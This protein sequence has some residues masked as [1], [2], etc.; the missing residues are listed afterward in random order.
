M[1]GASKT[2]AGSRAIDTNGSAAQPAPTI[3]TYMGS[4]SAERPA[5][6]GPMHR[7]AY[8]NEATNPPWSMYIAAV[9]GPASSTAAQSQ[10]MEQPHQS[11]VSEGTHS[12]VAQAA[13]NTLEDAPEQEESMQGAS[14]SEKLHDA[15]KDPEAEVGKKR[16]SMQRASLPAKFQRTCKGPAGENG[17]EEESDGASHHAEFKNSKENHENKDEVPHSRE[18]EAEC[19]EAEMS[20]EEVDGMTF[21]LDDETALEAG[22]IDEETLQILRSA[23]R[24]VRSARRREESTCSGDTTEGSQEESGQAESEHDD[25]RS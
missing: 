1:E 9:G 13:S 19:L 12:S 4:G 24:R 8:N 23:R 16:E 3:S 6:Q 10:E 14:L 11:K 2:N 21:S 17:E 18:V 15:C 7:L 22:L 5:V 25:V 20:I